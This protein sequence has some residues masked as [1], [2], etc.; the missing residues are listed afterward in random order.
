MA[1]IIRREKD[2]KTGREILVYDT[3]LRKWADTG[4]IIKA[5]QEQMIN[6]SEKGREMQARRVELTREKIRDEILR[7]T[8]DANLPGI[9]SPTSGDD[10]FAIGA[11]LVWSRAVLDSKSYPRDAIDG[12]QALAKLA[13]YAAER[14]AAEQPG[15]VRIDMDIEAL[16]EFLRRVRE[17][18]KQ[19][20]EGG[21]PTV[22]SSFLPK[23]GENLEN[24]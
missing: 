22:D 20:E 6:S 24:S 3:G 12:L 4:H 2:E 7:T 15:D 19:R 21:N 18:K 23:P 1:E 14:E 8:K 9:P 16:R 11:G 10:A 13:G 5:A 17:L